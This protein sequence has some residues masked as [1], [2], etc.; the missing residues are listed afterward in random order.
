M[1]LVIVG[2]LLTYIITLYFMRNPLK[3]SSKYQ[4]VR[5]MSWF[6]LGMSYAFMYMGRYNL[7]SLATADMSTVPGQIITV[8]SKADKAVISSAGFFAYAAALFFTGPLIDRLGGKKGMIVGCLGSAVMNFLMGWTLRMKMTGSDINLVQILTV[9]YIGNMIFQSLGAI[10]T[11]KVKSYW[12]HVRERGTFG[13]IFG[14]LISLGVYFAFDWIAA[15]A[16]SVD[17]HK[18]ND[19]GKVRSLILYAFGLN[20]STISAYWYIFY[21]PAGFLVFWAL[22]DVVLI[23]DSPSDAGFGAYDTHDASS[24]QAAYTSWWQTIRAV[25]TNRTLLMIGG[26]EF[27]AGVLRDGTMKWYRIYGVD[28]PEMVVTNINANWGLYGAV[29]GIVG[30]FIAGWAS[31]RFFHSRRAPVAAAGQLMMLVAVVVIFFSINSSAM[32]VG[33]GALMI[34]L[35]SIAVH[36]ILS[37]T[38]TADFG[39][40]NG[41]A[42]ATG[43]AD[44]FSKIGTSFQEIVLGLIITKDTWVYWPSFLFPFTI[45]GL[46]IAWKIWHA[47]PDATKRYLRDVENVAI[48]SEGS[49]AGGASLAPQRT[50]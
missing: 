49:T 43:I 28:H 2:L 19:G 20:G 45:L 32:G 44:G 5:F 12:F 15:I 30:A 24:G 10:S 48:G 7:D 41:A 16:N 33:V 42:T 14:T 26:I 1:Q 29:T 27:C 47:L 50:T 31:D 39:G 18:I 37:G 38:A 9:L 22:L 40:R 35:A 25:L 17:V 13:A 11:I 3:H 23:K 6:P 21:I 4:W 36:S 46:F 8:L 34:M